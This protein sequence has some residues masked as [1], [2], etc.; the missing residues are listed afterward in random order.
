M[1]RT[2][3]K[4]LITSD[5]QLSSLKSHS[6]CPIQS[7]KQGWHFEAL[8]SLV[9]MAISAAKSGDKAEDATEEILILLQRTGSLGLCIRGLVG[10]RQPRGLSQ[11]GRHRGGAGG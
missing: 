10:Y 3:S 1:H 5:A 11:G 9:K 6:I 8:G 4:S 2:I 7:I